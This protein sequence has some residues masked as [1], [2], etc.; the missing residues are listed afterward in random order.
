MTFSLCQ[1]RV[2][3][4]WHLFNTIPETHVV[5]KKWKSV[6]K[7]FQNIFSQ[8][9][10]SYDFL[11]YPR[12]VE[13]NDESSWSTLRGQVLL[14]YCTT[15]GVLP[16]ARGTREPYLSEKGDDVHFPIHKCTRANLFVCTPH[17]RAYGL[18]CNS[19]KVVQFAWRNTTPWLDDFLCAGANKNMVKVIC[20]GAVQMS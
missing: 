13:P 4:S 5:I 1:Q 16:C 3:H 15:C 14:R 10:T 6:E 9:F 20:M 18:K 19:H 7:T 11:A 12:V 2:I 8:I 17:T